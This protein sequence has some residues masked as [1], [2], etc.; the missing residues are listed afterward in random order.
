M[1]MRDKKI[2]S[3]TELIKHLKKDTTDYDGPVWYRGQSNK[4]WRLIATFARPGH[5]SSEQNLIK[6]FKQN[7]TLLLNPRPSKDIEWL[8]IMQ[9]H[10][11]K[12]R[13]LDW[14]ESP[15]TALYF[16]VRKKSKHDGVLWVL[17]PVDLN[18][19]SN[20]RP[21]FPKDIPSFEDEALKNYSP[22]SFAGEK[23]SKLYPLAAIAPRNNSRMQA[24]LSVFTISHRDD[25]PIED[26]GEKKHAWRYIIPKEHKEQLK[27]ELKLL[28]ISKF[29]LFPE[30]SSIAEMLHGE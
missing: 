22:E 4:E 15:L 12:T 13:L 10:G 14:T 3:L 5:T 7:A 8:F 29:Q 19:C 23:T 1:R 28:E 2:R 6:K 20:V 11:V 9:H 21:D 25:T 24:Q 16:A 26:I 17:L 30:L 18:K 27:A